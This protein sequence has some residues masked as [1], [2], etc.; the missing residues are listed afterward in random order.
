MKKIVFLSLVLAILSGCGYTSK[1]VLPRDIKTIYVD[2]VKNRI[3]VN[4]VSTYEPGL[5]MSITNA[6]IERLEQD[7]NLK[8]VK[9]EEADAVLEANLI[10]YEQEGVRF[11]RLESVQEYRLYIVLGI[12]LLEGKTGD[13]IWEEPQFSGDTE[14]FVS[15][16]RSQARGEA[17]VEAINRLSRNVVDRIVED[18]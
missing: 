11:S 1:T 10:A 16:V 8:V 14:Y 2:T 3:P 5:E 12:R 9:R 6:I 13:V 7:G 17:T 15:P 18:W 4:R